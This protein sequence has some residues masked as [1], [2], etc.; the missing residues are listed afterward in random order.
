MAVKGGRVIVNCLK[1]YGR[2]IAGDDNKSRGAVGVLGM[3]AAGRV[4]RCVSDKSPWIDG[5][6]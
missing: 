3:R 4:G 5:I 6:S 1:R 2:V